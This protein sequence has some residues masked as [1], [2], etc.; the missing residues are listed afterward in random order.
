MPEREDGSFS[1]Q[2]NPSRDQQSLSKMCCRGP[3][4]SHG[5][6]PELEK[7]LEKPPRAP[8]VRLRCG[9][10]WWAVAAGGSTHV[11]L[12]RRPSKKGTRHSVERRHAARLGTAC[13]GVGLPWRGRR[14][15]F[16]PVG[17]RHCSSRVE[18]RSCPCDGIHSRPRRR[19]T[20]LCTAP[21]RLVRWPARIRLQRQRRE[22]REHS[23][24]VRAR[25]APRLKTLSIHG[26]C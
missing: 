6:N 16:P 15:W 13:P 7:A 2:T 20:T 19:R 14:C 26:N 8:A 11:S 25:A 5:Q 9:E 12:A 22:T 21:R 1:W 3:Y 17:S 10:L 18:G 4:D 24:D 23:T